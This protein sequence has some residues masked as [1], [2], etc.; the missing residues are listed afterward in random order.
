MEDELKQ[1]RGTAQGRDRRRV[2]Q[3]VLPQAQRPQPCRAAGKDAGDTRDMIQRRTRPGPAP[4]WAAGAYIRS[5]SRP[6]AQLKEGGGRIAPESANICGSSSRNR[7]AV[8]S[9]SYTTHIQ[10]GDRI[11]SECMSDRTQHMSRMR[12]GRP[13]HLEVTRQADVGQARQVRVREIEHG[14]GGVGLLR[15]PASTQPGADR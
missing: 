3:Q 9:S 7:L 14:L 2:R 1:H 15:H 6:S 12:R 13:S 10:D 5:M 11:L 8:R 4:A